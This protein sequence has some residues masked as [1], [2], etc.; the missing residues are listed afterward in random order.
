MAKK[1]PDLSSVELKK[2]LERLS[3][4]GQGTINLV[5]M[6]LS[7]IHKL[8]KPR[9][10]RAFL[11]E[12]VSLGS[13]TSDGALTDFYHV[14][15]RDDTYFALSRADPSSINDGTI[16]VTTVNSRL[17]HRYLLGRPKT[18]VKSVL[19]PEPKSYRN[20]DQKEYRDALLKTTSVEGWHKDTGYLGKPF[21]N[22][23][24]IWFTDIVHIES[25]IG[26]GS[27]TDATKV[28]DA[29]GLIDTGVGAYLLAI[30]FP[31]AKIYAISTLKMARPGFAD[32]G[33]RRFAAYLNKAAEPIYRENWGVTVHLGKFRDGPTEAIN[34]IPERICS[35]IPLACIASSMAIKSLGCVTGNRGEEAGIDDDSA[36]IGRLIGRRSVES[37]INQIVK[38]ANKP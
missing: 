21:P 3:G 23:K 36:F 1:L 28:R 33:H 29:L 15:G 26:M 4:T 27:N 19:L 25:E 34:G 11:A 8:V 6:F 12:C 14:C 2:W 18:I 13:K 35:P 17:F 9:L 38:V 10:L 24:H 22:P 32:N 30:A 20:S 16:L 7:K 5:N 37:I 31:A